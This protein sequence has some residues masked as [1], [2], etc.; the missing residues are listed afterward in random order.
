MKRKR[1]KVFATGRSSSVDKA[2]Q[3]PCEHVGEWPETYVESFSGVPTSF[4]RPRQGK[5]ERRGKLG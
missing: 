4:Q 5:Q 1:A 2:T 3:T